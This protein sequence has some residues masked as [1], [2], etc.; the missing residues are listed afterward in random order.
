M[1]EP[2]P[3][4]RSRYEY[5]YLISS[6]Q[7]PLVRNRIA[8]FTR[9]DRFARDQPDHRYTISSLYLDGPDLRLYRATVEGLKSRF[10]LR[11]RCYSD[12]AR[13]P[14]FLEMKER[15]DQIVRKRR[16][17]LSRSDAEC[18]AAGGILRRPLTPEVAR[19]TLLQKFVRARPVLWVRYDREA[20]E[21]IGPDPIRITLDYRLGFRVA[22]DTR[23]A[24]GDDWRIPPMR[25]TILEIKFTDR[26]P[27]WA[28]DLVRSLDLVRSSC[29][30]YAIGIDEFGL[31]QN[32]LGPLRPRAK[33]RDAAHG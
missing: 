6:E 11:V 2:A 29:A 24:P 23:F 12:D 9:Y 28:A 33:E 1:S 16:A 10:K 17:P 32:G 25:P 19:F 5:K 7:E 22:T 31:A 30:K 13:D 21:S 20:Y 26:F 15:N 4:P 3:Y 8:P 14:V 27:A 18:L